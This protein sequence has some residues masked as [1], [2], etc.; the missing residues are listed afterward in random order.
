MTLPKIEYPMCEI[1]V[2]SLDRKVNFRPFLVKE[3]KILLIAK[4]S[5]DADEIRN[6]VKQIIQNCVYEELKI[7]TL[8][9]FDIEYKKSESKY[10]KFN[11]K[12]PF[13]KGISY[14]NECFKRIEINIENFF[15]FINT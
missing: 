14:Y 5:K 15:D 1:F 8:P 13:G 11:I 3:E 2:H 6:A 4:E 9:L 12:D 10:D 7:E